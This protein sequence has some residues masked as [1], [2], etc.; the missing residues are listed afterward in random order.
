MSTSGS[1]NP[2]DVPECAYVPQMTRAQ[3]LA[4]RTAGTLNPNCVVVITDGP[5]IGTVGN[6]SPT[7]IEL[8]PVSGTELGTTAR[9]HTTFAPSAWQGVYD[10]DLGT[11][12]TI[13]ELRDDFGNTA[14]DVDGD[15]ATVHTQWP[16]HLGS[17]TFRDNYAEDATLTG[18]PGTGT[19]TNNRVTATALDFT[20][21]NAGT[22]DQC[23]FTG[24]TVTVTGAGTFAALRSTLTGGTLTKAG[25]GTF[26]FT[27]AVLGNPTI[28]QA[29]GSTSGL[30][31]AD[32]VYETPTI[33]QA[34]TSTGSITL[35][36]ANDGSISITHNGT[37]TVSVFGTHG[38]P[39]ITTSAAS[40]R[41]LQV[42]SITA[43]RCSINQNGT[44][45][46]V[47]DNITGGDLL[48]DCS[49]NFNC[50]SGAGV[51]V[52]A[53]S[54]TN[55]STLNIVDPGTPATAV[56]RVRIDGQ[57]TLNVQAGGSVESCRVQARAVVNTG[58][59]FHQSLVV[60]GQFTKTLTASNI[61]RLCNKS[62]DDTI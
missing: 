5:T 56:Q 29:V 60:D 42:N 17:A 37:G 3:A 51:G 24:T 34:A 23:E 2:A 28:T 14:K 33:T 40:T 20:G 45:P 35:S 36:S 57:S 8:N 39:L 61:N 11:A 27:N 22:V 7:Q 52:G 31:I 15:A 19:F 18:F 26:T 47:L 59:F 38:R 41:A 16:W 10:I 49:I 46:V 1:F 55:Q 13:T 48:G 21:K 53:C 58:A 12:G 32:S 43:G 4:R 30:T 54:L 6:T 50:T 9:V 62:F 44:G 25:T